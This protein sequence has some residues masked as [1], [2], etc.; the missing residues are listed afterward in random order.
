MNVRL[1]QI[2]REAINE[3]CRKDRRRAVVNEK[4]IRIKKRPAG[5]LFV[6]RL[7]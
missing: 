3:R 7:I 1:T 5:A 6:K 4:E 2:L